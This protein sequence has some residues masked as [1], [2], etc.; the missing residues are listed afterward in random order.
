MPCR[1]IALSRQGFV[2]PAPSARRDETYSELGDGVL[3]RLLARP[4]RLRVQDL[5][6][7]ALEVIRDVEVED[8]GL[9][10]VGLGERAVVDRVDDRAGVLQRATLALAEGA[11]GPAAGSS[12]RISHLL[13]QWSDREKGRTRC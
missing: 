11:T 13:S 3:V 9:V 6:G 1:I 4:D 10:E 2:L 5:V 12:V 7:D 8:R